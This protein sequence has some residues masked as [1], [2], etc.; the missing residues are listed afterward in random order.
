[1]VEGVQRA[2]AS[3]GFDPGPIDGRDGPKT[4]AAVVAF[5]TSGEVLDA[6]GKVGPL[7]LGSNNENAGEAS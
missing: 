3:L 7:T 1:M 5:Q 4:R 2:P 6:D